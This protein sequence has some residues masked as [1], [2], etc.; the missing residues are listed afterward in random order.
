MKA[1]ALVEERVPDILL[2]DIQMPGGTGFELLDGLTDALPAVVF[3]TAFDHHVPKNGITVSSSRRNQRGR[4][5][6]SCAEARAS[7]P[8][9]GRVAKPSP[10]RC[11]AIR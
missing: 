2:L 4:R 11:A 7:F 6:R 8:V 3:V 10:A 5:H 9:F 1:R